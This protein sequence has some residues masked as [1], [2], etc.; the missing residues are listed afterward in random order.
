MDFIPC[1]RKGQHWGILVCVLLKKITLKWICYK[2]KTTNSYLT[3]TIVSFNNI[4]A[5]ICLTQNV[6]FTLRLQYYYIFVYVL[7]L[8]SFLESK[9]FYNVV[10][11]LYHVSESTLFCDKD[12]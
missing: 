11:V 9:L 8:E 7:H 6:M 3:K 2:H 4:I 1:V 5:V 10:I 12:Y